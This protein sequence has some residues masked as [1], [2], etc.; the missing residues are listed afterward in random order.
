MTPHPHIHFLNTTRTGTQAAPAKT[1][2]RPAQQHTDPGRKVLALRV[3][4]VNQLLPK[5]LRDTEDVLG[6]G[7]GGR[8]NAVQVG[9]AEGWPPAGLQVNHHQLL[10]HQNHQRMGLIIVC[11]AQCIQVKCHALI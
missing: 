4:S 9:Q 1:T 10:L 2:A 6:A 8:V 5:L 11:N 3:A 7:D